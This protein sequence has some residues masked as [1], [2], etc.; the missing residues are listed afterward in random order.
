[1]KLMD[2]YTNICFVTIIVFDIQ[3]VPIYVVLITIIFGAI[4]LALKIVLTIILS[5][6]ILK[7]L[8]PYILKLDSEV[9]SSLIKNY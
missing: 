4:V 8:R 5:V 1:M 7:T 6:F 9:K 3:T 2:T